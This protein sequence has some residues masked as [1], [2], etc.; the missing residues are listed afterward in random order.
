[1]QTQ[2]LKEVS[3]TVEIVVFPFISNSEVFGLSHV[4]LSELRCL[5]TRSPIFCCYSSVSKNK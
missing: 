4:S 3:Q 5:D 1:M 2:H